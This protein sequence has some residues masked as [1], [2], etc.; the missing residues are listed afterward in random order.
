MN[1][2]SQS[3]VPMNRSGRDDVPLRNLQAR[4]GRRLRAL[5]ARARFR[6]GMPETDVGDVAISAL[7]PHPIDAAGKALLTEKYRELF[8]DAVKM[9][10]ATAD[11]L[12]KH[13]FKFL[14]P[15]VAHRRR[16]AL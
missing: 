15:R 4:I 1:E 16:V 5:G 9:E 10:L 14:G 11:R 12:A 2:S 8:P 6:L 13:Q 7:F 3:S